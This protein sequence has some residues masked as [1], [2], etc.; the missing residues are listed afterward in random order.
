M[1]RGG[2]S[3]G[4]G[5]RRVSELLAHGPT[6]TQGLML[7]ALVGAAIAGSTLWSRVREA[8][9]LAA[10]QPRRPADRDSSPGR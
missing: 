3:A 5:P 2:G 8:Q 9:R 7:G 6:F 4:T 1:R 10:A